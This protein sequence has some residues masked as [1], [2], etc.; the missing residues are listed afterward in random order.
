MD[1][2]WSVEMAEGDAVLEV[3]WTDP[4]GRLRYVDLAAHPEQIDALQEVQHNPEL[5]EFLRRVNRVP[6]CLV[7]VKCDVWESAEIE[8]TEEIYGAAR[9]V[10]SYCDVI[11][12]E[13]PQRERFE[14]H[15]AFAK[16]V[17]TL[18]RRA[19]ELPASVEFVLRRCVFHEGEDTREGFAIT[20]FVTGYGEDEESARRRWGIALQLAGNA[21][22]QAGNL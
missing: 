8:A 13:P 1:A 15:E 3:P 5:G 22:L 9:K 7:S 18:L 12:R 11:F 14:V 17:A 2:D 10:G 4:D 21:L 20:A 6:G 19:P 16:K